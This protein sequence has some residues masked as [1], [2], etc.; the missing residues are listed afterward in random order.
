MHRAGQRRDRDPVEIPRYKRGRKERTLGADCDGVFLHILAAD[1]D[2]CAHRQP[3]PLALAAGVAHRAAVAAHDPAVKVNKIAVRVIFAGVAF[4]KADIIAVRHK[5]DVLTVVLAGV[6]EALLF[7]NF[8]DGRLV[9]AAKW[10]LCVGKLVLRQRVQHIALI[11]VGVQCFF[12]QPAAGIG[13]LLNAG[14]VAGHDVIQPVRPGKI[15]HLVKFHRAVAVDAGV[16]RAAGLIGRNELF[17]DLLAEILCV[18]H[19][20]KRDVQIKGHLGG[21]L[22]ILGRAAGVEAALPKVLVLV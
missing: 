19:D 20:L 17:D 12:Q 11:L 16:R 4:H 21:V 7:G 6:A 9:H 1:I 18:V 15:Q 5:A 8:A 2:R 3:Q 22:N 14:I 13:V 10:E